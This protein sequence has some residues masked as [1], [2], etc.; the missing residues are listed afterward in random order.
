MYFLSD[1][2]VS[3]QYRRTGVQYKWLDAYLNN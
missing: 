2:H 1:L 3:K